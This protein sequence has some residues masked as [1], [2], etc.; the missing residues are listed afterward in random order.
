MHFGLS[1]IDEIFFRWINEGMANRLFDW[2]MPLVSHPPYLELI[3]GA[4]V[5]FFLIFGKKK[6][7]LLVLL[8]LIWVGI[9]NN[10]VVDFL[11]ELI[12]RPR[13]FVT[14][15]GVRLLVGKGSSYSMPSGHVAN[16][17]AVAGVFWWYTK[18]IWVWIVA[19]GLI[20]GFSRIYNGVHYPSDVLVA[21][22]IG[23]FIGWGGTWLSDKLWQFIG[24]RWFSRWFEKLPRLVRK[25]VNNNFE[26]IDNTYNLPHACWVKFSLL[27]LG[28]VT[29]A[30]LVYI[31]SG[32]IELSKDEAYQWLW[33]KRLDIAYYSKPPLIAW[34][35]YISTSVL[36]DNE[37]GVRFFA[38]ILSFF[39]GISWVWFC[40]YLGQPHISFFITLVM[41]AIPL[42]G[43]GGVLFTV[44]VPMVTFAS[45]GTIFTWLAFERQ[46]LIYWTGAG[47]AFALAILAK[48]TAVLI[49]VNLI[50][51]CA[52]DKKACREFRKIG[53]YTT[54]AISLTGLVPT[55]IWNIEHK[56]VTF[57]HIIERGGL[58]E[59]FRITLN[60]FLDFTLA[61][62]G[63][64][65]P[66]F[67]ILLVI[68]T[69]F[70]IVKGNL[71]APIKF[72]LFMSL[73]IYLG[74]WLYSLVSRVLPNWIVLA[75]PG[76]LVAVALY[77]G[78]NWHRVKRW[79]QPCLVVGLIIGIPGVILS[80]QTDWII[81]L[82]G[83]ALPAKY[84]PLRRVRYWSELASEIKDQVLRI[85]RTY[86]VKTIAIGDHYGISSLVTF[87]WPEAK[88]RIK[89][90]D[91]PLV[92]RLRTPVPKDQFYFWEG[93]EH[94]TGVNAIFFTEVDSPRES[95]PSALL[96]QFTEV[97]NLG[98]RE[99][100]H[101]GR[102]MRKIQLFLAK[103]LKP[104][105]EWKY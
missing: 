32:F 63:L 8:L 104:E 44:D 66:P 45:I 102:C 29:I 4:G 31:G 36:G 6:D 69:V 99:F 105:A 78:A 1:T 16:C 19:T 68:L 28:V 51:Y 53:L 85:E 24:P 11:K 15:E 72:L 20:V 59:P 25:E 77:T 96:G 97:V 95:A 61:Q 74:H 46:R 56:W 2:L 57:G 9:V 27:V 54:L 52:I 58:D 12:A 81:R 91:E 86:G 43:V 100:W 33:A 67:F 55:I 70:M 71:Q 101:Y 80:H 14:L 79:I 47:I 42:L 35:Q 62:L 84:D 26:K 65:N 94:L 41:L 98:L 82:T 103:G 7:R 37:L 60:Y 17:F 75:L 21:C 92:Y 39:S 87:Y 83:K 48:L 90:C 93:Y 13:P 3:I 22:I 76:W 89:A 10:L 40:S 64:L 73:P 34:L 88:E 18:K 30:R 38:P 23:W 50:L 5:L 49:L